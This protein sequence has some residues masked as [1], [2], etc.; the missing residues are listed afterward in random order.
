MKRFRLIKEKQFIGNFYRAHRINGRQ[1]TAQN[2][3]G[4]DKNSEV[5]EIHVAERQ[6]AE[7]TTPVTVSANVNDLWLFH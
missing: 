2:R 3:Y 1:K 5:P 7:N 6:D 4:N